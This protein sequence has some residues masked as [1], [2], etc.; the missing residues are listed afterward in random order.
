MNIIG[1]FKKV[2]SLLKKALGIIKELV[3]EET[4]ALALVWV[5]VAATKYVD[6]A[7]RRE[8]VVGILVAKKIPEAIARLA[9]EIA[10]QLYK[11]EVA[12]LTSA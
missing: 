3:P 5:R 10:V 8:W 11:K 1:F 6:N 4:L 2:G 7:Q 12:K 9:V